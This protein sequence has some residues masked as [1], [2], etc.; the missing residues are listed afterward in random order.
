MTVFGA[1][2]DDCTDDFDSVV[3]EELIGL[4]LVGLMGVRRLLVYKARF[5]KICQKIIPAQPLLLEFKLQKV[6]RR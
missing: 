6:N 4:V 3:E 2:F 1:A 5:L